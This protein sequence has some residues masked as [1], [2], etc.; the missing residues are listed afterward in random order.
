VEA[1]LREPTNH[2]N[3]HRQ[4]TTLWRR[5]FLCAFTP[6]GGCDRE[7]FDSVASPPARLVVERVQFIV[8]LDAQWHGELVTDLLRKSLWLGKGDVMGVAGKLLAD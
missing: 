3:D 8:M 5:L 7:W 6:K 2:P 4:R 1:R